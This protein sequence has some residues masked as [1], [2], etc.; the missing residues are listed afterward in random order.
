[1][2]EITAITMNSRGSGL[3]I[4]KRVTVS[5]IIRGVTEMFRRAVVRDVSK[6]VG[7]TQYRRREGHWFRDVNIGKI[8]LRFRDVGVIL[9][10]EFDN[11]VRRRHW[12]RLKIVFWFRD[13]IWESFR[14]R[15]WSWGTARSGVV[16]E[17]I[18]ITDYVSES[19]R[20][21]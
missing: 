3:R 1:M 10:L 14:N 6:T 19:F 20:S 7:R 11:V 13:V 2:E 12:V 5:C 16:I 4:R 8:V 17:V 9:S 18:I 21:E 15:I